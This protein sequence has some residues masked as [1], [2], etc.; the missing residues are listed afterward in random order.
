M[1][2]VYVSTLKARLGECIRLVKSGETIPVT[3]RVRLSPCL[4]RRMRF[5]PWANRVY[6]RRPGCGGAAPWRAFG[7][8]ARFPRP[9]FWRRYWTAFQVLHRMGIRLL[10]VHSSHL[11]CTLGHF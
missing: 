7:E 4:G 6:A 10:R 2:V 9:N 8:K 1:K 5:R 11:G 3:D